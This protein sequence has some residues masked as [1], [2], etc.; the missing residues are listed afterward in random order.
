MLFSNSALT[1]TLG[2][3]AIQTGRWVDRFYVNYLCRSWWVQF[4]KQLISP[5]HKRRYSRAD[6]MVIAEGCQIV[7][8]NHGCDV[9]GEEDLSC[10]S[11]LACTTSSVWWTGTSICA[12]KDMTVVVMCMGLVLLWTRHPSSNAWQCIEVTASAHTHSLVLVIEASISGSDSSLL[13]V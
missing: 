2:L 9:Q 1:L 13:G 7:L 5:C 8:P 6:I 4:F 12:N 11:A 10:K 3:S